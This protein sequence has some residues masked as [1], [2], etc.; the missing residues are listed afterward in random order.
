MTRL[1]EEVSAQWAEVLNQ[2]KRRSDLIPNLVKT[3]QA[4]ANQEKEIFTA[5]AHTWW[6]VCTERLVVVA[7]K[8]ILLDRYLYLGIALLEERSDRSAGL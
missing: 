2:Y 6:L 3:V 7:T 4:Y 1:D 8:C 5:V